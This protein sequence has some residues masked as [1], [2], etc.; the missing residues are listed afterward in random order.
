MEMVLELPEFS[1][2]YAPVE[3]SVEGLMAA[4]ERQKLFTYTL[5]PLVQFVIRAD[6]AA[7]F[8]YGAEDLFVAPWMKGAEWELGYRL[9]RGRVDW[10]RLE[11]APGVALRYRIKRISQRVAA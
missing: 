1:G 11:L 5:R 7:F 6:E 2:A 3:D 4:Y 10:N 9:P 8:L